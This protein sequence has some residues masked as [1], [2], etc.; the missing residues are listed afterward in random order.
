MLC[1]VNLQSPS[2]LLLPSHNCCCILPRNRIWNCHFPSSSKKA[3]WYVAW[4]TWLYPVRVSLPV[5]VSPLKTSRCIPC[6]S[7]GGKDCTA[8]ASPHDPRVL[9]HQLVLTPMMSLVICKANLWNSWLCFKHPFKD[10]CALLRLKLHISLA[11]ERVEDNLTHNS[12]NVMHLTMAMWSADS[13]KTT[14]IRAGSLALRPNQ[15]S[16]LSFS[17]F[18][19]KLIYTG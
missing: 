16:S 14:L 1:T 18:S 7:G 6:L 15:E 13:S 9:L 8:T 19:W 4:L 11:E 2:K 10:C 17:A 12:D 5:T 3:I